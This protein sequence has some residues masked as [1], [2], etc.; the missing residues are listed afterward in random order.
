MKGRAGDIFNS[1]PDKENKSDWITNKSEVD[2]T[3]KNRVLG[4]LMARGALKKEIAA[5]AAVSSCK[6]R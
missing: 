4:T 6:I 3:G 2:L 1:P 5:P